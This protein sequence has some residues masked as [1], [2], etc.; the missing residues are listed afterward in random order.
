MNWTKMRYV[1]YP[2]VIVVTLALLTGSCRKEDNKERKIPS[3]T[4]DNVTDIGQTSATCGGTVSS[5]GGAVVTGRG[6]CWST[7]QSPTVS[8][9]KTVDGTGTGKFTSS[10]TGLAKTSGI[11]TGHMRRTKKALLMVRRRALSRAQTHLLILTAMHTIPKP[12]VPSSGWLKTFGQQNLT[13][14][15]P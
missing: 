8:D 15:L 1:Y 6:V 9:S 4:T 12:S 2:F 14:G 7:I 3:I 10:L 13:T 5:D 11:I